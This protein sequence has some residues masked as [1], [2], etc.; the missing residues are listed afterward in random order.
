MYIGNVG[1]SYLSQ[2]PQDGSCK[3]MEVCVPLH[4][5]HV[6][7]DVKYAALHVKMR[8]TYMHVSVC[9]CLYGCGMCIAMCTVCIST[10]DCVH[11]YV[12]I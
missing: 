11:M 12:T 4:K 1:N 8:H 5:S 7:E 10:C 9:V 2:C 3:V 6:I